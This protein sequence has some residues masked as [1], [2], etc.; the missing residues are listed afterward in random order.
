MRQN[1]TIVVNGQYI[2]ATYLTLTSGSNTTFTF[3]TL[4]LH[5]ITQS[6]K[7]IHLDS[8]P[9]CVGHLVNVTDKKVSNSIFDRVN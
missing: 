5:A 8:R 6:F 2:P 3:D 1:F 7:S 9:F 4:S